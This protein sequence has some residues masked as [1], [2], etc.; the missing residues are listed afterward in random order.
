M[1]S[2]PPRRVTETYAAYDIIS[3]SDRNDRFRVIAESERAAKIEA[4]DKIGYKVIP[5][6]ISGAGN[7]FLLVDA[8][9]LDDVEMTITA[10]DVDEALNKALVA[11]KW[12]VQEPEMTVGGVVGGVGFAG[13]DD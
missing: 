12:E 11:I 2:A 9:D 5:R 13:T 10:G 7:S 1:S 8:D 4:L 3:T 6:T